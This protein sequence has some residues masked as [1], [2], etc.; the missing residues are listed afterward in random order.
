MAAVTPKGTSDATLD[1]NT[2]LDKIQ[3]GPDDA[4]PSWI[5]DVYHPKNGFEFAYRNRL[6][7]EDFLQRKNNRFWL[8]ALKAATHLKQSILG[9]GRVPRP[10]VDAAYTNHLATEIPDIGETAPPS[11]ENIAWQTAKS[12]PPSAPEN[13][14]VNQ[15]STGAKAVYTA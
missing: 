5:E 10:R 1:P 13:R 15:M 4:K 11:A 9:V 2:P 6:T 12:P 3:P 7:A 8:I 14:V